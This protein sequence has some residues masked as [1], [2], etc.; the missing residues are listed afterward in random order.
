M[1]RKA[2]P[3]LDPTRRLAEVD[4]ATGATG[5]AWGGVIYVRG[6]EQQLPDDFPDDGPWWEDFEPD[7]DAAP[8]KPF[9]ELRPIPQEHV[10]NAPLAGPDDDEDD[11]P[12]PRLGRA[13]KKP[14]RR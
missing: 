5:K 6:M 3:P 13:R 11:T 2:P 12:S 14:G 7:S 4:P 9:P 1:P 8:A 10:F